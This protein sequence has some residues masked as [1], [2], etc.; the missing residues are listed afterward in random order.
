MIEVETSYALYLIDRPTG[1]TKRLILRV[2]GVY[3]S[4]CLRII[5]W[6]IDNLEKGIRNGY[7]I[8]TYRLATCCFI[9][10]ENRS[11]N[12]MQTTVT[13]RPLATQLFEVIPRTGIQFPVLRTD[14][15]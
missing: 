14:I 11:A 12:N 6:T 2:V 3:E 8:A 10:V 1:I 5:S 4:Y 13:A 15:G 7:I 9:I